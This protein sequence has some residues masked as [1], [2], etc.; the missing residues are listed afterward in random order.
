MS[1]AILLVLS[2]IGALTVGMKIG[3][4]LIFLWEKFDD[5][6]RRKNEQ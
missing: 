2:G 4:I 5:W 1:V 3:D 6:R